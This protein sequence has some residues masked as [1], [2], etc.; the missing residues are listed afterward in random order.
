MYQ[1]NPARKIKDAEPSLKIHSRLSMETL[2]MSRGSQ[3][4][5]S[6]TLLMEGDMEMSR[7]ENL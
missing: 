1:I 4:I 5:W 6:I 3:K 7:E 2:P